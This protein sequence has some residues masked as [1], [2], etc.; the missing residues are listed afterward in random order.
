MDLFFDWFAQLGDRFYLAFFEAGRWKLY[1]SGLGNTLSITLGAICISTVLGMILCLMKIS[2]YRVLRGP[3][4]AYIDIIRGIPVVV[5]LMIIYFVVLATWT[6]KTAVG[7]I[8]FGLNS[9]AYTAEIFRS[10][11]NAVDP[12]QM[13]AGRSLGLNQV[14]TMRNIIFPQAL[15]NCLPTYASEFIV[16]VKETAVVGYI[17]MTDLTK[18][19]ST[20]QSRTM[21][22]MP[23]LIII[24][25]IYFVIT[26]TLSVIFAHMERRL[27]ESDRR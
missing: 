19:Y 15:K 6:N 3:A 25:V 7:I 18:A 23:P 17:G 5:Q 11:I 9:A 13:E 21:D 2:N 14:Q 26:K 12:G 8:A 22:A 27:R 1:L 4:K 16:L 24:A 20:V 10:G